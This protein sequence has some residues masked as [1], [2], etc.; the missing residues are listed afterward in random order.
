MVRFVE[1]IH[2]A[3]CRGSRH[4]STGGSLAETKSSSTSFL[5]RED[6]FK[7]NELLLKIEDINLRTAK[8][9]ALANLRRAEPHWM[10]E[11][12]LAKQA[13]I[14]WGERDWNLAPELVRRVPQIEKAIA[15]TKAAEARLTQ[16]SFGFEPLKREE[17]RSRQ[18]S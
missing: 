10:Q 3:Y 14:E 2:Y 17:L 11:Q 6:F 13:K 8:A 4:H 12:E 5:E 18:N 7:K 15:E 16:A 9:E 1:N